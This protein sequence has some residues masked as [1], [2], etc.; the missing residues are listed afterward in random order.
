MEM[1]RETLKHYIIDDDN[2]IAYVGTHLILD[3]V[4]IDQSIDRHSFLSVFEQACIE[5]G[6]TI[7][8]SHVEEYGLNSGTTGIIILAESHLSWHWYNETNSIYIDLFTCG[9][10]NP[11]LAI[12]TILKFF[13]PDRYVQKKLLRGIISFP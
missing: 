8:F 11:E 7:L 9:N 2:D 5:S 12:P 1:N 4:D 6:A 13:R 3:L 10:T